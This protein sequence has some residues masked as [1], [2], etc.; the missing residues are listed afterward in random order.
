MEDKQNKDCN[1]PASQGWGLRERFWPCG[2]FVFMRDL[3]VFISPSYGSSTSNKDFTALLS[4]VVE[5]N[6]DRHTKKEKNNPSSWVR[7]SSAAPPPPL[8]NVCLDYRKHRSRTNWSTPW[9]GTSPD[10]TGSCAARYLTK[11]DWSSNT[12]SLRS[13]PVLWTSLSCC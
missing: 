12:N 5:T 9:D 6:R 7:L 2:T 1:S 10:V 11:G 4:T 8:E 3:G 13:L